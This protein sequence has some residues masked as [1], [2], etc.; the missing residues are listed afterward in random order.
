MRITDLQPGEIPTSCILTAKYPFYDGQASLE[1]LHK[2]T[3]SKNQLVVAEWN[4]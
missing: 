4:M 1:G 2:Q 3:G